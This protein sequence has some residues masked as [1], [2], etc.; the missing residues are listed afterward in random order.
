[1]RSP[2]ARSS[3]WL[4]G[5]ELKRIE[6]RH[7]HQW[8]K[9]FLTARGMKVKPPLPQQQRKLWARVVDE[10]DRLVDCLQEDPTVLKRVHVDMGRLCAAY[11]VEGD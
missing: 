8:A 5:P 10:Y 7:L 3:G 9:G 2:P 4:C 1:M 11:V 6:T